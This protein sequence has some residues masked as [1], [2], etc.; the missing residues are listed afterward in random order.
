MSATVIMSVEG[1]PIGRAVL[2]DDGVVR[3]DAGIADVVEQTFGAR[4]QCPYQGPRE[5]IPTGTTLYP[6]D[7]E[8]YLEALVYAFRSLRGV[9]C[10]WS[11]DGPPGNPQTLAW[12]EDAHP[13]DRAGR[14]ARKG[15][16]SELAHALGAKLVSPEDFHAAMSGLP[17]KSRR[18]LTPYSVA[19]LRD[20][21]CFLT[22]DGKVGGALKT[23]DDGVKEAVSIFN[24][25]GPAGSGVMMLQH[26]TNLG[27][28]RLDCIGPKLRKLYEAHGYHVSEEIQWDDQYAPEDWDFEHDGRPPIYVMTHD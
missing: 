17:K 24:N 8:P 20:M 5:D 18:F 19:E 10:A 22:D 9:L 7:G 3:L 11:A 23:A 26:L 25:G 4:A 14:F 21:D 13:R 2:M 15:E 1:E 28:R 6:E 16:E 27:A 12:A